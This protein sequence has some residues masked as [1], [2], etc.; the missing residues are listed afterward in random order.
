M[1]LNQELQVLLDNVID[2]L[3]KWDLISHM[4]QNLNDKVTSDELAAIIGRPSEDVLKALQ[5]LTASEVVELENDASVIYY[6]FNPSKKWRAHIESFIQGLADR[7][8]RWLILNYIV[9][10]HGLE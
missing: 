9:E 6:R 8:T 7:N 1:F 2:N 4:Q 10:K 3:V 5:D